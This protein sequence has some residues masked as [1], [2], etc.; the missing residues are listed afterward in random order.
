MSVNY[1][2]DIDGSSH[3]GPRCIFMRKGEGFSGIRLGKR[4][5]LNPKLKTLNPR[6]SS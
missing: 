5:T 6:P 2:G 1:A 4:H 3:E